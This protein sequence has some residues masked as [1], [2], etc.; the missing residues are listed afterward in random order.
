M[1]TAAKT[2]FNTYTFQK[3]PSSFRCHI[4]CCTW[5][6]SLG[7]CYNTVKY[8]K[9]HKKIETYKWHFITINHG[10]DMWCPLRWFGRRIHVLW[11]ILHLRFFTFTPSHMAR[12]SLRC[13]KTQQPSLMILHL[14]HPNTSAY[15]VSLTSSIPWNNGSQLLGQPVGT[16]SRESILVVTDICISKL[17]LH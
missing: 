3:Q 7:T 14:P 8:N 6:N 17:G 16:K 13:K 10:L 4:C 9:M 15:V 1:Y 5:E 12:S 2:W 11:K